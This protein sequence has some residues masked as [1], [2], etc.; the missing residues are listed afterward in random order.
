MHMVTTTW[1][2][3]AV[4]VRRSSAG[5][6]SSVWTPSPAHELTPRCLSQHPHGCPPCLS[7]SSFAIF[8]FFKEFP[9][10]GL[11]SASQTG[12]V[13]PLLPFLHDLSP[14]DPRGIAPLA[15]AFSASCFLLES[16]GLSASSFSPRG[17]QQATSS[18]AN[19]ISLNPPSFFL[20]STLGFNDDRT[21]LI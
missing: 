8:Y 15:L 14:S 2:G 6:H 13:P 12:R 3:Q 1:P 7:F 18:S 17:H 10:G 5:P 16:E 4:P 20:G 11:L 9:G 19:C 21:S